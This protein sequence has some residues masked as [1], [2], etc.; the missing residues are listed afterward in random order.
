MTRPRPFA[1]GKVRVRV[2]SGPR[3]DGRYRWRADKQ[4]GE[5]RIHIWSGWGSEEEATQEVIEQLAK[6]GERWTTVEDIK[7]VYDL[8]DVWV[9]DVQGADRSAYTSTA[10]KGCA[11][12]VGKS[13]LGGVLLTRVDQGAVDRYRRSTAYSRATIA[14]DLKALR[15]AWVWGQGRDLVPLRPLPSTRVEV[16]PSDRVYSR[17]TPSVLE[18][19]AVHEHLASRLPWAA[20]AVRLLW[21]TGCR[22]GEIARLTWQETDL[23]MWSDGRAEGVLTV[24]GKTGER[25]VPLHPDV[26]SEMRGWP[27]ARNTVVG[28]SPNTVIARLHV[29]ITN[30][31]KALGQPRWS[32]Y[33][34]RR[35]AVQQLYRSGVEPSTAAAMLGH[36]PATAMQHYRQVVETDMAEAVLRSGLGALPKAGDVIPFNRGKG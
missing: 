29:H 8:L 30:A 19:A 13:E 12:R 18:V 10:R 3:K 25:R 21:A 26:V 9:A 35:A 32:P 1:V 27:R 24:N 23:A 2:H 20:R 33:G 5:T 31:C 15:A 4:D 7:T 17:Y 28:A 11:E 34:L 22:P 6:R 36:S 14:R 16:K